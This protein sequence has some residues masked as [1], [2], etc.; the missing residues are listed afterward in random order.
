VA[1]YVKEH[2]IKELKEMASFKSGNYEQA[3]ADIYLKM[4]E[5]I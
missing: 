5:E 4:D 1:D 3:L 2:L